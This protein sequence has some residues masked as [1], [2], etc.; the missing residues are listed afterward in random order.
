MNT[1]WFNMLHDT[2]HMKF[3]TITYCIYLGFL[4]A[5]K[6]MI[7]Q[8]F[9]A[10]NMF[11]QTHDSFFQLIIIDND[12]HSLSPQYI[13]RTNKYRIAYF[14][15][16]NDRFVYC[17]RSSI[18]RVRNFK[19][20]QDI[21]K[22]TTVLSNIH[23]VIRSTDDPDPLVMELFCKF[24]CRLSAK[25]N[26]NTIRSFMLNYFPDMF[27]INRFEIKF[28]GH[29]KISTHCLRIAIDHDEFIT[30]FFY[31]KQTM[32][33]TIIKF[34]SLPDTIGTRSKNDNFLFVRDFRFIRVC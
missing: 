17:P 23:A 25:L 13:R 27:P 10:G 21:R 30:A 6:K 26:N 33:T 20:F 19:L 8:Y 5:I 28:I 18:F 24:Q 4:A 31:G 29:I 34:N 11:Q 32:H 1:C 12:P 9:V 2:H 7:N 3:L 16:N 14:I 15:G 22:A